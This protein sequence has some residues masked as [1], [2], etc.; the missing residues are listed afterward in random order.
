MDTPSWPS[1]IVAVA[2]IA[3]VGL[4]FYEAVN[5]DFGKVWAGTGSIVGILVEAFPS[6]FFHQQAQKA[7]KR[8]SLIAGAV[9][10]ADFQTLVGQNPGLFK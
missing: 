9:Q 6:Y 10:P 3:L 1:A 4:M 8:A 7:D 5:H 2:L